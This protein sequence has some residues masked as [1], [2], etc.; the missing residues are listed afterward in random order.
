MIRLVSLVVSCLMLLAI[1]GCGSYYKITEP[2]SKSVYYSKDY[3]KT[4]MGGLSF[5]DA[6]TGAI[7][8]IQNSEIKEISRD[9]F[10]EEVKK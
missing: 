6:K 8:T 5:K 2:T 3:E 7:V 4:K 10:D 9:T 1:S